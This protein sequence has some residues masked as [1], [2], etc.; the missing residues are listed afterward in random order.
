M[1][2]VAKHLV[3]LS[4]SRCVRDMIMSVV[5][6]DEVAFIITSTNCDTQEKWEKVIRSY[7]RTEWQAN[8]EQA[9]AYANSFWEKGLIVQPRV[10]GELT[11]SH[12]YGH[13]IPEN[14]KWHVL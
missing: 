5:H 6:P 11:P 4:L 8:P 3:G 7:C 13:W 9:A 1:G 12:P 14:W 2:I 10:E